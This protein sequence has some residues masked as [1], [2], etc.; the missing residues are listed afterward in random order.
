MKPFTK[1]HRL[2]LALAASGACIVTAACSSEIDKIERT[3]RHA[4]D[5][6]CSSD[7]NL[8]LK[9]SV[10]HGTCEVDFRYK[11]QPYRVRSERSYVH[12]S[13][14]TGDIY[15]CNLSGFRYSIVNRDTE[16]TVSE[17]RVL[18]KTDYCRYG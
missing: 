16:E 11:D 15:G 3:A 9:Q 8:A 10:P 7:Y 18:G 1:S 17:G 4:L 2:F 5:T 14:E 6:N 12:H 13:S